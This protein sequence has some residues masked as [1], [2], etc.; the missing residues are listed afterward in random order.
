MPKQTAS[1]TM[2]TESMIKGDDCSGRSLW[3]LSEEASVKTFQLNDKNE[4]MTNLPALRIQTGTI[5]QHQ[6][7]FFLGKPTHIVGRGRSVCIRVI[8]RSILNAGKSEHVL[9]FVSVYF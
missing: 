4:N 6:R 8:Y 7:T 1:L 2:V 3:L 9:I 5:R